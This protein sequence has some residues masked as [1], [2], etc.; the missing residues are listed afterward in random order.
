MKQIRILCSHFLYYFI[1]RKEVFPIIWFLFNPGIKY[2]LIIKLICTYKMYVEN[3]SSI[4]A[5]ATTPFYYIEVYVTLIKNDNVKLV[6][7]TLLCLRG[8][9][10]QFSRYFC[11]IIKILFYAF[12]N[13]KRSYDILLIN[14]LLQLVN[15]SFLLQNFTS[16]LQ[17]RQRIEE[18]NIGFMETQK[19]KDK[20]N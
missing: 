17:T 12:Q 9:Y 10:A 14:V 4:N 8:K 3:L 7:K 1:T 11:V 16:F 5:A 19:K 13:E 6:H 18:D 15:M 20:E 2:K